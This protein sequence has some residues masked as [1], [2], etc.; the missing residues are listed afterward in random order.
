MS[1]AND[2]CDVA[3]M[4]DSREVGLP[5]VPQARRGGQCARA[6]EAGEPE[7]IH[8]PAQQ[9]SVTPAGKVEEIA[10]Q[11]PRLPRT[12]PRRPPNETP[13][14]ADV[15]MLWKKGGKKAVPHS[16]WQAKRNIFR[17][18][19]HQGG[20][21]EGSTMRS[22]IIG[23]ASVASRENDGTSS[24][25]AASSFQGTWV[26]RIDGEVRGH[27]K[28]ACLTWAEDGSETR[29]KFVQ[30][31][32]NPGPGDVVNMRVDGQSHAGV[33]SEDGHILR[34]SDGDRWLRVD[35][36]YHR[37]Q[38]YCDGVYDGA[39]AP[40]Q[41][42]GWSVNDKG[43]YNRPESRSRPGTSCF[44]PSSTSASRYMFSR[45]STSECRIRPSTY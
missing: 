45:P 11:T 29:L 6:V 39:K 26:S 40:F 30:S 17:R 12:T 33:L 25:T 41:L 23:I 7:Q 43:L 31:H 13:N 27:I 21:I 22:A 24:F 34:W 2:S 38:G 15:F 32:P 9:D 19:D 18:A 36:Q 8:D 28:G 5:R 42:Q 16:N 10:Q 14:S 4:C 1:M 3:E 37:M 35:D 20:Y 44:R